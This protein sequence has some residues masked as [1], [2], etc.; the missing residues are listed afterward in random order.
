MLCDGLRDDRIGHEM[1]IAQRVNISRSAGDVGGRST[2]DSLRRYDPPRFARID[3]RVSR[4]LQQW[5]QPADFEFRAAFDQ[6][7]GISELHDETGTRI[8]EMRILSR[9][10]Q[11]RHVN[12][13]ATDFAGERGE[14][15]QGR[16]DV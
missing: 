8:D 3:L 12:L 4:V 11:D 13:V 14:I 7:I 9:F 15:G 16:D 2:I 6:H 5:R 1:R 10:R